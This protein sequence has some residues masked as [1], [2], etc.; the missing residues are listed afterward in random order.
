MQNISSVDIDK[1]NLDYLI[2][3]CVGCGFCCIKGKCEAGQR[4]YPSAD[5][6]PALIWDKIKN[7][8]LCNLM[9]LPGNIGLLYRLELYAG[10]GCCCNLNTWRKDIKNRTSSDIKEELFSLDPLFQKF[11]HYLSKEF[12]SSDIIYLCLSGLKNELIKDGI[13]PDQAKKIVNLINHKIKSSR[14]KMS[15]SFMG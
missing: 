13:K 9:T 3:P 12:I 6:C 11:L 8:Y 2:H 10:E 14:S 15:E 4:L 7:R 1:K 5:P